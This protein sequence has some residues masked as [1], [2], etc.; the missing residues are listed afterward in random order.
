M[1][2]WCRKVRRTRLTIGLAAPRSGSCQG[3][4]VWFTHSWGS[5]AAHMRIKSFA[6]VDI[7]SC[8]ETTISLGDCRVFMNEKK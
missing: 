1:G 4:N 7:A 2:R 5:L 3:Q 6:T 8:C